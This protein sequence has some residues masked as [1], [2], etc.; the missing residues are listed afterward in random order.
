MWVQNDSL[1]VQRYI[2]L[3]GDFDSYLRN[4]LGKRALHEPNERGLKL[5][6]F[7]NYFNLCA[8]KLARQCSGPVFC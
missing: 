3:I 1:T 4:S 7:D 6:E 8:I 2:I 5:N